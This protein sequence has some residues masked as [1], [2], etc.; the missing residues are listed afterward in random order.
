MFKTKNDFCLYLERLKKQHDIPTYVETIVYFYENETDQ[1]MEDIAKLLNKKL[2]D[3]IEREA[4]M[5]NMIQ[6]HTLARLL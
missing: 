3:S 6:T 5:N 1:E 2:I 4:S